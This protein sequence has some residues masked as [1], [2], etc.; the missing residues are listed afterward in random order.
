MYAA[1]PL[2]AVIAVASP[3]FLIWLVWWLEKLDR[4]TLLVVL[5]SG[6]IQYKSWGN[7]KKRRATVVG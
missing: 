4:D 6:F 7:Q 3:F 1:Y 2:L 5:P